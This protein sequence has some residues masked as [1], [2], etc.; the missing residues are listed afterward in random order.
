MVKI[1]RLD[2]ERLGSIINRDLLSTLA[3]GYSSQSQGD[4]VARGM[5]RLS[6]I[7]Q[8]AIWAKHEVTTCISCKS[9]RFS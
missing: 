3:G 5:P 4:I 6:A 2:V 1:V 8:D 7:L 9:G